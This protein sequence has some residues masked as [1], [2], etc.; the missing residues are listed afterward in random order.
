[1]FFFRQKIQ[2]NINPRF[3]QLISSISPFFSHP[4]ALNIYL[5]IFHLGI[6]LVLLYDLYYSHKKKRFENGKTYQNIS[7]FRKYYFRKEKIETFAYVYTMGVWTPSH[8]AV[9]GI[10]RGKLSQELNVT[11]YCKELVTSNQQPNSQDLN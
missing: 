5:A 6:F 4:V 3:L 7:A 9:S 10:L 11:E 2:I 1:M 8:Q